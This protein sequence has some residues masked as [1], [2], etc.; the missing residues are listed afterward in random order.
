MDMEESEKSSIY[1][2]ISKSINAFSLGDLDDVEW[3]PNFTDHCTS[4]LKSLCQHFKSQAQLDY[5]LLQIN[6][7][8]KFLFGRRMEELLESY[9]IVL[10]TAWSA[11]TASNSPKHDVRQRLTALQY[12]KWTELFKSTL[13]KSI[14]VA[15]ENHVSEICQ[16]EYEEEFIPRLKLWLETSIFPFVEEL[17]LPTRPKRQMLHKELSRLLSRCLCRVRAKE[18][19]E[20]VRDFPQSLVALNELKEASSASSNQSYIGKVFRSAVCKRLLHPGASTSQILDMCVMTMNSQKAKNVCE[21]ERVSEWVTGSES[22]RSVCFLLLNVN[23]VIY[24]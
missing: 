9:G 13:M 12:L 2:A 4:L 11:S 16:G 8:V 22:N 19:F 23:A 15:I 18:L 1:E 17:F 20:M 24:I 3:I 10:I 6:L 14:G 7:Q 5:I 21:R